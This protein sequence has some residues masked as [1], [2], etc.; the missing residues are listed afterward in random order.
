[1]NQEKKK[2]VKNLIKRFIEETIFLSSTTTIYENNHFKNL[3]K[4]VLKTNNK[5]KLYKTI[6]SQLKKNIFL[7]KLLEE[8]TGQPTIIKEEDRGKINKIYDFWKTH[9]YQ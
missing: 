5:K 9:Q 8:I 2:D 7:V 4:I 6:K 3:E 1:M